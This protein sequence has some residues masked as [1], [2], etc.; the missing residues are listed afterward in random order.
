VD[1]GKDLL[2]LVWGKLVSLD[3]QDIAAVPFKPGVTTSLS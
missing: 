3:M 2:D 1:T